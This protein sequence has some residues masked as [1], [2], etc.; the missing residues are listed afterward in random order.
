MDKESAAAVIARLRNPFI[1]Y[2]EGSRAN[3]TVAQRL[4][5]G[6]GLTAWLSPRTGAG[7]LS[8][9]TQKDPERAVH[10]PHR[11]VV[12]M[13]NNAADFLARHRRSLVDHDL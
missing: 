11:I 7:A 12:E 13:A 9:K 3:A 2:A 5:R 8:A 10:R 4:R 1:P 6:A